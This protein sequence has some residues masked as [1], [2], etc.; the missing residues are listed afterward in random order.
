MTLRE[1]VLYIYAE[2]FGKKCFYFLNRF[3][4]V[5]SSRGLGYLNYQNL[6]AS[7]ERR[8]IR[9]ELKSVKQ[10]RRKKFIV[11]DVGANI[12]DYAKSV[13]Q[14][15][16]R[17]VQLYCFEP[18]EDTAKEL[19]RSLGNDPRAKIFS[20]ALSD[21]DG[22]QDLYSME[23]SNASAHASL[24]SSFLDTVG[25]PGTVSARKVEVMCGDSF[26]ERNNISYIS[27]LKID[28]EGLE[29]KVLEGFR[30]MIRRGAID[31]I[32]LE[33]NQTT[34]FERILLIDIQKELHGYNLFR[35]LTS[36]ELVRLDAD[37]PAIYLFQNLVGVKK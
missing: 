24:T 7:G 35:L 11:F 14:E 37:S 27:L 22:L 6:T 21:S 5:L 8:F 29:L 2:I 1:K 18:G 28:V 15:G 32:Q 31:K 4:F 13:L 30:D 10:G 9:N 19:A 3:L 36:G 34:L 17:N 20:L 26:C 23:G 25:K 12:G 16:G 33:F